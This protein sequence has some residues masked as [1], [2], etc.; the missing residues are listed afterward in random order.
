VGG[1]EGAFHEGQ[2][3]VLEGIASGAPLHAVLTR[4]VELVEARAGGGLACSILLVDRARGVVVHGAAPS[5]PP[6]Y[7][8]R[9]DGSP[10]GSSAGSCGTA[11]TTG[12]RVVVEDVATSPLWTA[13]RDI[14]LAHGLRACWSS[15]IFSPSREVLGTFAIY[16]GEP[17]GPSAVEIEWVDVAT[18]LAAIAIG[19]DDSARQLRESESRYRHIVDT[20]FEG[21]W[22]VDAA[23]NV[24]FV[25]RRLAEMLG[26]AREEMLGRSSFDFMD[27]AA[28]VE[29]RELLARRLSG[30]SEQFEFRLR[31]K[32]GADFW[33]V[34]A[35]SPV[36]DDAGRTVGALAMVTDNNE[37][38]RANAALRESE[39]KN[40]IL[41]DHAAIGIALVGLD[42]RILR[43][44]AAM[45]RFLGY[46]PEE[47]ATMTIEGFSFPDDVA[48]D[49]PLVS[50]LL[51]GERSSY[52]VEK[53]YRRKDG[54]VVWGRLVVTCVRDEAGVPQHTIG[55]VE[56]ITARRQESEEREKLESQ[57]RRAQKL[58]SLGTL[59]SG[60]AHDFNNILTAISG[61]NQLALHALGATGDAG[62]PARARLEEV[63]QA[64][65]RAADLVQR[66]LTFSRPEAARRGPLQVGP[67]VEEVERLLRASAPGVTQ[68]SVRLATS[69]YVM[70][71]PVQIHQLVMNLGTNAIHALGDRGGNVEIVVEDVI[72]DPEESRASADLVVGPHVRLTV[73]DDGCG[74]T[75]ELQERIFEPFFTT[76]ASGQGTGLGLSVV[77]GIVRGHGGALTV[78]SQPD[79]GT[80]FRIWFPIIDVTA[81][82]RSQAASGKPGRG[83]HVLYVDDDEALVFLA[84][85]TL[86]R[87]GYRVSGFSAPSHALQAFR[88]RPSDYHAVVTDISMAEMP[89]FTLARAIRGIRPEIPVILISGA[90]D[91]SD[92]EE[93]GA[94]GIESLV[95][96][97][98]T[99]EELGRALHD[100][101]AELHV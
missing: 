39:E 15:P 8:A 22:M 101:L 87:M 58:Q 94:L 71:D 91:A 11:A 9:I 12:E 23:A 14:A 47:I 17:R 95:A 100:K 66:L 50:A 31:R 41:F 63:E 80:T 70:A 86:E 96:K 81:M 24:T 60:I 83:E 51:S 53:R 67:A 49:G 36:L 48:R 10:I 30:V 16:Y 90:F 29:A 74:M 42:R 6:E 72:V 37:R 52:E 34:I 54:Q 97:P 68:V 93:A 69:A 92:L 20:A 84:T 56:D 18:H 73:R 62:Q 55:L 2:L 27:E 45:A 25:N 21:V 75:P 82:R 65:R 40:R 79:H 28:K 88:L 38:R 76:R 32:D 89:G 98:A 64:T 7:V 13:Y 46:T 26:Y 19:R 85:R 61:H 57:L 33:A 99:V 59:A 35:S 5:L 78:Q 4:I 44:N 77:H 43:C 3:R 1:L